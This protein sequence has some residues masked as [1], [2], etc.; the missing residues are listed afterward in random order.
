[1]D[2]CE[3]GYQKPHKKYSTCLDSWQMQTKEKI[4]HHE[5]LSKPWEV[6]WT[7]IFT[8]HNKNSFVLWTIT[9]IKKTEDLSVD[10]LILACKIIFSEYNLP[11]KIMSDAG[12]N[13]ISD[14]LKSSTKTLEEAVSSSYHHQ[15]NR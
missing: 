8:L 11:K 12:G 6:V 10:S 15:N 3:Y 5:I 4:S 2:K 13:F 9:V 1:M 14:N 7:D